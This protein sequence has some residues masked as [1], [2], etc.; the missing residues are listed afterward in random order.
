[1]HHHLVDVL[2]LLLATAAPASWV[3]VVVGYIRIIIRCGRGGHFAACVCKFGE[4]SIA[5]ELCVSS[6][7]LSRTHTHI[8]GVY[9]RYICDRCGRME[10]NT[11]CRGCVHEKK[12][13]IDYRF[14][15]VPGECVRHTDVKRF[16][17]VSST[18]RYECNPRSQVTRKVFPGFKIEDQNDQHNHKL[19][20]AQL[21]IPLF[22][23]TC[24][25]YVCI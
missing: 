17:C 21:S 11:K 5:L 9:K 1:M 22:P 19:F 7:A 6:V 13:G 3:V 14:V 15:P 24:C 23:F 16:V 20:I 25:M 18:N 2:L 8:C 12:W 4:C 10:R